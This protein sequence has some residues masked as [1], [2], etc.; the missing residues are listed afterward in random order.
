MPGYENGIALPSVPRFATKTITDNIL[1]ESLT[2]DTTGGA[3]RV[4]VY[5]LPLSAGS[6]LA[7]A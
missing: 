2:Q 4:D 7:A 6:N 1:I 5:W 3:V